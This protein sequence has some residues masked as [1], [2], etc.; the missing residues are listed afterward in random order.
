MRRSIQVLLSFKNIKMNKISIIRINK[1]KKSTLSHLYING[2]FVCYLLE[3]HISVNK[4]AGETCFPE[5][6]YQLGINTTAGMNQFY[7][8]RFPKF[9]KGMLEI[10][11]IYNFKLVFFH[12]GNFYN[13]TK[14]CPLTGMSWQMVAGDFQVLQS[15]ASY[16]IAYKGLLKAYQKGIREIEVI[17]KTESDVSI[18]AA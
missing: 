12:I 1:G 9:H 4:I 6:T 8:K 13:D 18:L 2:L 14:G 3:D 5:G 15:A 10:G 17:N 16:E 11:G 7:Q